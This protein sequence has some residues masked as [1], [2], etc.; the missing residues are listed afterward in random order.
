MHFNGFCEL[1]KSLK[2]MN[3]F[4]DTHPFS[5]FKWRSRGGRK[6]NRRQKILHV[7]TRQWHPPTIQ[8]PCR[9]LTHTHTHTQIRDAW[10]Q[11]HVQVLTASLKPLFPLSVVIVVCRCWS[12]GRSLCVHQHTLKYTAYMLYKVR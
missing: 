9:P 8:H 6:E 1:S 10:E 11:P 5:K 7:V 3:S 2:F 4:L 12:G